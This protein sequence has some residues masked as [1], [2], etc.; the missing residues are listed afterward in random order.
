MAGQS[1]P[2]PGFI[3]T[4]FSRRPLGSGLAELF[5]DTDDVAG[6]TRGAGLRGVSEQHRPHALGVMEELPRKHWLHLWRDRADGGRAQ[7]RVSPRP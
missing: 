7:V 5:E 1:T 6:G 2:L 3:M 4:G